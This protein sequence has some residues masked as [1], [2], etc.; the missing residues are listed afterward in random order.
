VQLSV[1]FVHSRR[2]AVAIFTVFA[3]SFYYVLKIFVESLFHQFFETSSTKNRR[4]INS[5]NNQ[6]HIDV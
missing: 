1:F 5:K 2:G 4:K 3:I 6:K